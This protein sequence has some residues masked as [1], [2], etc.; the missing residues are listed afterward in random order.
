MSENDFLKKFG[1]RFKQGG[2][3]GDCDV[4]DKLVLG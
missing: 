1:L 3:G 4:S 2:G